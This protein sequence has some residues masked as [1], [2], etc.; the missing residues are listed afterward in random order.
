MHLPPEPQH[1]Q[2]HPGTPAQITPNEGV[3]LQ[4]GQQPVHHGPVHTQFVGKLGD[5]EPVV[6]VGQELEDT[7]S[8]V[9]RLRGLRGH[10]AHSSKW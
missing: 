1:S 3:L 4:R 6:R 7:Q 2:P 10:D 8:P 9:K 5:G